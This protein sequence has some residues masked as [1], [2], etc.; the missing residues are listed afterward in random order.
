M[1]TE[2]NIRNFAI[3]DELKIAFDGGLNV[4]SGETGAGKSI[5][6]GAV[7]LLLGDRA[8]ADMIRSFEDAAV[9][10]AL[11]NIRDYGG[12]RKKVS[13]M[14]FGDGDDLIVRRVVS[15]S[16][17]NRI[18]INGALASLASLA[19]IG[20]SL[21]NICGQHE[22]QMILDPDNH[23]DIL[24]EFGGLLPL[25]SA[26][27]QTYDRYRE[28]NEKHHGLQE[29]RRTR[30]QREDL[31]RFQIGEI[32]Q[33]DILTGEDTALLDEKKILANVQKLID[34]AEA[35][36][37]TLYGKSDSVLTEFRSAAVAVKEIRKIDPALKLSEGDMEELYYRIED[38][39][40][41]LRDYAKRHTFDPARMEAIEARLE[42][43]GRLK[44]KYGGTLDAVL[45]K[46]AEAEEELRNIASVEEEIS[47][48]VTAIAAE[49]G[50]L[51]ENAKILSGRRREKAAALKA[52]I[53]AEIRTLGMENAHFAVVFREIPEG[54]AAFNEKGIDD[55]E[56]YLSTNV[57]EELKPLRGIASGGELSRIMLAIKKVL[58]RTGS[59][60]TIVFD[61]VD[62]GIGGATAEIVGQKLREVSR[63]H[64]VLCITHLPQIACCGD[65]HYQVVKRVAG[66]R[67]NTIVSVLSEAQRLEEIARM[68]GGIELT[69]K[70]RDHAREMLSAARGERC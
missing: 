68:L 17:K 30:A 3:I 50:R 16:G 18:Y 52:T 9:V 54:D 64:Q 44:R 69:A 70:T 20:E 31:L 5:I 25:R 51:V 45:G 53:E 26:Y 29:L 6:I 41:T 11:F 14:G 43:L 35:G 48:L 60:G 47:V 1:L 65:R 38:A 2:L 62:S 40:F 46:A 56:F 42:L 37:D 23:T 49:R 33:A 39:A 22:H 4:I 28:L 15:R 32:S 57:G 19:S 36:Y 24:D 61:E 66:K 59:V 55:P 27:R 58:A 63:H 7:G 21:I 12:L 67:T 13:E 34:Y 8:N 10:E